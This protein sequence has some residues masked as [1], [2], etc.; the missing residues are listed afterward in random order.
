[1][2]WT[3]KRKRCPVIYAQ[4]LKNDFKQHLAN[5]WAAWTE[6]KLPPSPWNSL[7]C[8]KCCCSTKKIGKCQLTCF[9]CI[10][11]F[12][13]THECFCRFDSAGFK[14][15]AE[16]QEVLDNSDGMHSFIGAACC[17][18]L[19]LCIRWHDDWRD[20]FFCQD[21]WE[22]QKWGETIG[23]DDRQL[24]ANTLRCRQGRRRI[25]THEIFNHLRSDQMTMSLMNCKYT[26][27]FIKSS[28][29]YVPDVLFYWKVAS[30]S[31]A[32]DIR[33][34][35]HFFVESFARLR[36]LVFVLVL[37]QQLELNLFHC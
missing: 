27:M 32:R 33:F 16:L 12:L 34:S 22:G 37:R 18:D 15:A 24:E 28:M 6:T 30:I 31:I 35:P 29:M 9:C 1:M 8:E 3:M 2:F 36:Q 23:S 10:R 19:T 7:V 11:M 14:S 4:F 25:E 5:C 20:P 17:Q 13:I 21:A 26:Y